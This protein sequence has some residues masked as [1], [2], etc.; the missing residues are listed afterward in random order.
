[1]NKVKLALTLLT[2]A[3]IVGPVLGVVLIYRDNLVGLVL[4][5]DNPAT[6]GLTESTLSNLNLTALE[7]SQP[8]KPISDPTYNQT[9]G[10]FA[11]PVNF[12]NP[13]PQA[14]SIDHLSVDVMCAD[15]NATLGT[16]CIPDPI[17]VNPGDSAVLNITGNINQQVLDQ[18]EA[19]YGSGNNVN[20]ALE[21]LNVTVGGISLH[22]DQI[23]DLGTIQIPG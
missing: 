10:T 8:I 3:L 19:Q 23:P 16:I 2:V 11:Y 9:T 21:N 7:S 5:P 18:Y 12:T 6:S 1:M 14:I 15:N 20:I 4:P 22:L 17:Q 13:L